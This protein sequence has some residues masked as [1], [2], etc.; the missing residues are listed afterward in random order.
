MENRSRIPFILISGGLVLIVGALAWF[1]ISANTTSFTETGPE[2][3]MVRGPHPDIPRVNLE[4]AK[5]AYDNGDAVF[6]DVRGDDAYTISHIPGAIS[7]SE[8]DLVN[9][10]NELSPSDWI[11]TY[12][13]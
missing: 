10:L 8:S 11:I 5:K 9:R 6:L 2:F 1:L 4:D 13:T 3:V 12:C 7:I